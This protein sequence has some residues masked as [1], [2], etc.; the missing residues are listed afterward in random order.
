MPRCIFFHQPVQLTA[1]WF[2]LTAA[3]F[4]WTEECNRIHKNIIMSKLV[5]V[6]GLFFSLARNINAQELY[7]MPEGAQ[8][9]VSSFENLNG[10]KGGGALSNKGAKGNAFAPV[11]AGE[12]KTLLDIYSAGIINRIWCTISDRSPAMLRSLRLRIYWDGST[13]PAV[14][15]PFGDFFCA[16]LGRPAAF[17]SAMFSDPEGRSFICYIPMPFK[18][19]AR[20]TLT[21][22]GKT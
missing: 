1:N 19:G 15:V 16:G 13:K 18:S 20:I 4:T 7:K 8:S 10:Q 5:V 21:N 17:Q 12:T 3:M 2:I 11:K 14:D 9:R 22:E 6:V